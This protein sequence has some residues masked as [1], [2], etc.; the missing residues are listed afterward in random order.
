MDTRLAIVITTVTVLDVIGLACAMFAL[1]DIAP[2]SEEAF[3]AVGANKR[4][5]MLGLP[6]GAVVV[7]VGGIVGAAVYA[8]HLRPKLQQPGVPA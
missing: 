5:W 6:L 3:R 7:G 2:R 1:R 8:L 4:H